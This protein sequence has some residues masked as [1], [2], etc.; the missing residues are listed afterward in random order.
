[1]LEGGGGISPMI[2][3][4]Y[5]PF[6]EAYILNRSWTGMPIYRDSEYLKNSPE[7][8]K[9]YAS[10]DK[11]LVDFARWLNSTS[12]GDD[13]KKGSIDINPAKIEY[14][15]SGTF[16]GM[17]S[18]PLE[19]K[20]TGETIFGARDFEWRN[21]PIAKRLVKSG[22]ERTANRK[23]Q[24][25]YFNYRDEYEKTAELIRKY[26]N[27]AEEDKPGYEEKLN[28]LVESPEYAR[29]EIFKDYKD[30]LDAYRHDIAAE[31]DEEKKKQLQ[32]EMYDI[33]QE[34]VGYLRDPDKYFKEAVQQ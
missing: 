13:Y 5:K 2:P 28:R 23:L 22:D 20:K 30:D 8:T 26:E 25:E 4:V 31:T 14:L 34:L 24:N 21:I 1:M 6:T 7:W 12:G 10:T 29:W 15:L 9:A 16:G 11:H 32:Q 18:F 17:Y 3:S 27:A 33:I 19:L